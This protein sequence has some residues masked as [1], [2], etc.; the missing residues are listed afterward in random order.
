MDGNDLM[1]LDGTELEPRLVNG[2]KRQRKAAGQPKGAA[3]AHSEE[4]FEKLV[5]QYKQQLGVGKRGFADELKEW[6]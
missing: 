3:A 1:P 6:M 5:S 2:K 4:R